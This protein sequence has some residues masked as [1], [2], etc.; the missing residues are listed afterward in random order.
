MGI[1][2]IVDKLNI[3]RSLPAIVAYKTSNNKHIIDKDIDR[4]KDINNIKNDISKVM[5]LNWLLVNR[6]EFRNL[7]YNRIN[8]SIVNTLL[9][10]F[11][12]KMNTLYVSTSDIGAGLFISHGF[13][14]I[15]LANSIGEN[16]WINQQVTIGTKNGVSTPPTIGNNVRIGAGAIVIGNIVIGD[17]SFIGAGSV[18]TKDVP[19][20]C[21][22]VGNPGRIIKQN[23]D[24][25]DIAL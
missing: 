11:Y 14:T 7:F 21:V 15:I 2:S 20:N 1:R 4:W 8:K 16:C 3:V 17:N 25:V 23:G 19:E 24:K 18:V 6:E 22:V 5:L 13:S 10:V 9:R 12:P